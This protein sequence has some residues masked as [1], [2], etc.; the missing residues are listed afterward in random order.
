[1]GADYRGD[2]A[3]AM[4]EVLDP[5][6]NRT[7]R[8]HYLDL[9]FDL[10]K[11]LFICT[12]N[13]L[14]TIP[15][16]L[17]DR[18]DTI[19]LSGYTEAEKL[20]IAKRYLLPK[21]LGLNGLKRS[22]LSLSDSMLRL[23]H[24]RV[25]ARGRG[26]ERSSGGSPTSAA[27]RRPRLPGAARRSRVSTRSGC[28]TGSARRLLGRG[29]TA[30]RGARRGDRPRLHVGR[31]RRAVHRGDRVPG[32][33]QADRHRPDRRRDAGVG[34]RSALV[35]SLAHRGDG[36]A[37]GLV[38]DP[39]PPYP[40]ARG[41]GAEGRAVGR[42][43]DG[44]GDR[45]ARPGRAGRRRRRHDRRDHADRAGAAD[46]RDPREV[47]R[48][49]AGRAQAGDPAAGERAGARRAPARD[50]LGDRVHP[51][52]HDR[53]RLRRRL[54]RQPAARARAVDRPRSSRSP[55]P[56]RTTDLPAAL[57]RGRRSRRAERRQRAGP[58]LRRRHSSSN[59]LLPSRTNAISWV[60][61]LP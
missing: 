15:G 58:S 35:G 54:R 1:M 41:S 6:Q 29:A 47:A 51:R 40:R 53:G 3:S 39:R 18:M 34:A 11:V 36:P 5:E 50:A 48:G 23:D 31:R 9:P 28:A 59:S 61:P 25:H 44:D 2:P 57:S 60:L 22:Q 38:R 46:R 14:D 8:D 26:A 16:P 17:L 52:E 12:A 56:P 33:G 21:Q 43:H 45:L 32:Q 19:S 13:T 24:P 30:H 42:C 10:S 49:A 27:R 7:F 20:G 37:G 55:R 4:L